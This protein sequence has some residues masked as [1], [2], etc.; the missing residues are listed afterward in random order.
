MLLVAVLPWGGGVKL[1]A[2]RLWLREHGAPAA[3]LPCLPAKALD[4]NAGAL[5]TSF[6]LR[7]WVPFGRTG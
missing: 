7:E 2:E 5:F 1:R 6:G 4:P 3:V